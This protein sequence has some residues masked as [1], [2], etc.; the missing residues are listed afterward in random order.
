MQTTKEK[1]EE[2]PFTRDFNTG[3]PI[4]VGWTQNMIG[5]GKRAGAAA[6]YLHSGAVDRPNLTVLVHAHVTKLIKTGEQDGM[7]VFGAVE[8]AHSN[9]LTLVNPKIGEI[10]MTEKIEVVFNNDSTYISS[11]T[12]PLG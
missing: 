3:H 4:G 11:T 7:P 6:S 8:F 12:T 5:N 2:F 9:N 1:P 10:T